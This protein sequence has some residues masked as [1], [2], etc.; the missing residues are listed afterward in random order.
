MSKSRSPITPQR[1]R[2]ID[3][4]P[5]VLRKIMRLH[6]DRGMRFD[7]IGQHLQLDPATVLQ[8]R[9]HAMLLITLALTQQDRTTAKPSSALDDED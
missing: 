4:L 7:E 1:R 8:L 3:K 6:H 9:A 5:P 2:A